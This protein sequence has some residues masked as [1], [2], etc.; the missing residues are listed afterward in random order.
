MR[1]RRRGSC[2][3]RHS[4]EKALRL[5]PNA[6]A[7]DGRYAPTPANV[8]IGASTRD[9]FRLPARIRVD[10]ATGRAH[11]P[12]EA[13]LP[14]A[15][16]DRVESDLRLRGRTSRLPTA[17][18]P[19]ARDDVRG[20]HGRHVSPVPRRDQYLGLTSVGSR[21]LPEPD[22]CADRPMSSVRALGWHDRVLDVVQLS[23]PGRPL[24][25]FWPG[26]ARALHD[27]H[28]GVSADA[29]RTRGPHRTRRVRHTTALACQPSAAQQVRTTATG[30]AAST[31][32]HCSLTVQGDAVASGRP[33]RPSSRVLPTSTAV[34]AGS[35]SRLVNHL[36]SSVL[37]RMA[38][39][40]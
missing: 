26:S 10:H 35:S 29:H 28:Y 2:L 14:G 34:V 22:R 21:H 30:V 23:L 12:V 9:P 4:P 16:V 39:E 7:S 24:V 6:D 5:R 11:D 3:V 8:L 32:R 40:S 37:V 25:A 17:G 18:G 33:S 36:S 27:R 15:G 38:A 20:R 1:R 31:W 13:H 19:R